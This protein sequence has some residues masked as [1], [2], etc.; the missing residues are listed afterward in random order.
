MKQV[1]QALAFMC[2]LAAAVCLW[3][4]HFDAAFVIATIGALAWFLNFRVSAKEVVREANEE[5]E[6]D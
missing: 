3:F 4:G 2:V 1:W 6:E 5:H